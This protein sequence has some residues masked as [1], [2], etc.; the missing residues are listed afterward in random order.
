[1]LVDHVPEAAG[2]REVRHALEH[3][4]GRAVGERAVDDVGMARHPADIGRAP[5]DIAVVIIE[6]VLV[7]HRNVDEIAA[8]RVQHALR[9]AGRAGR[10][11]DEERVLGLHAG[12]RTIARHRQHFLV[13]PDVAARRPAGL[14]AG[15]AHDEHLV[16]D[17][18][19]LGGD[20]DRGVGILLER[21][22]LAAAHAL[23][24][25]DDEGGF[26]VDDAAGQRIRREA[27][28]D[29]GMDG[30]DARAGEHRIGRFRDH[31]H[32]DGDAVALLHAVLLHHV[33]HAA[34]VLVKL[35]IGDL[36][37]DIGVVAFPDDGDLIAVRLQVPVDTIVGNVGD[38]V[39]EPLDRDLAVERGV[40]DLGI[41]LEPVDPHAVLVPETLRVLDALA[42][43]VLVGGIVD[44][45]AAF[46]GFQDRIGLCG[47]GFLLTAHVGARPIS[48]GPTRLRRHT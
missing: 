11:E 28:E 46:R 4:R 16:D 48:S 37:V 22:R 44:Q 39:L 12:R 38:A 14:A 25:G 6:D 15:A 21:D 41:G 8:R 17:D 9:L 47:H 10:V 5:V 2:I 23:V 34:D 3:Q 40:L 31:R 18:V 20:V 27:A 42:I 26:A 36:L 30:A 7:G 43:P 1:M 45:R 32:V 29:D 33:R 35:V 24:A 13:V 19:L